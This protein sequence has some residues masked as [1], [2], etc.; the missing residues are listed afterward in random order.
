MV[1][2]RVFFCAGGRGERDVGVVLAGGDVRPGGV[3]RAA[4]ERSRVDCTI[5]LVAGIVDTRIGKHG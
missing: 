1:Q 5:E 3:Q 4:A 2:V